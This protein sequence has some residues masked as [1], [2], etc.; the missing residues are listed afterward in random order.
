MKNEVKEFKKGVYKIEALGPHFQVKTFKSENK[1][2]FTYNEIESI[3]N[4]L[5]LKTDD[6]GNELYDVENDVILYGKNNN[7][8]GTYWNFKYLFNEDDG[9]ANS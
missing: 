6:K 4:E 7:K 1:K 3:C 2:G 5:S 8:L 9:A